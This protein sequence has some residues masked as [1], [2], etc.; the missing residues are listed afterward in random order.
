MK[1]N[2][3]NSLDRAEMFPFHVFLQNEKCKHAPRFHPQKCF[4]KLKIY[5]F[6]ASIF[7]I[8]KA[9]LLLLKSS[10]HRENFSNDL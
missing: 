8:F 6:V 10:R 9:Y 3:G 5:L 4:T 1:Q 7:V 2:E